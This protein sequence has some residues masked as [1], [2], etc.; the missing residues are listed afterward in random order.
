MTDQ[1][2]LTLPEYVEK[3]IDQVIRMAFPETYFKGDPVTKDLRRA[4]K[5]M[6]LEAKLSAGRTILGLTISVDGCA[7]QKLNDW[8]IQAA[9][10]KGEDN[11]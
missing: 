7:R 11:G 4:I 2:D 1:P 3:A 5:R 8:M 9:A 6:E 10:L